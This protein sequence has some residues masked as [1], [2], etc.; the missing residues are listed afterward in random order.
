MTT[1]IVFMS[2]WML[3]QCARLESWAIL[4][5]DARSLAWYSQAGLF[6]SQWISE[7][8]H[9]SDVSSCCYCLSN[10]WSPLISQWF[11]KCILISFDLRRWSRLGGCDFFLN[12]SFKIHQDTAL[13]IWGKSGVFRGFQQFSTF[14]SNFQVKKE[15]WYGFFKWKKMLKIEKMHFL[16]LHCRFYTISNAAAHCH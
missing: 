16:Y 3:F 11:W 15:I 14:F 8:V 1:K 12:L 7:T 2:G 4:I 6:Y 10:L 5:A 13:E 9:C